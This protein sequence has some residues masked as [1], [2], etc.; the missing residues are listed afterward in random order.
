[1][2]KPSGSLTNKRIGHGSL[3]LAKISGRTLNLV[4]ILCDSDHFSI[5][6]F[7]LSLFESYNSKFSFRTDW[8]EW[9]TDH[10][11]CESPGVVSMDM[12]PNSSIG[13]TYM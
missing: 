9:K 2:S 7:I 5:G 12:S 1:M 6:A 10:A 13:S 11:L 4:Y 8:N 3:W